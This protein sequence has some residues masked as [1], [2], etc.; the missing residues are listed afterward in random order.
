MPKTK[1]IWRKLFRNNIDL[2]HHFVYIYSAFWYYLILLLTVHIEFN[3]WDRNIMRNKWTILLVKL[4]VY[5][6]FLKC[7]IYLDVQERRY[8]EIKKLSKITTKGVHS[9]LTNAGKI[10]KKKYVHVTVYLRTNKKIKRLWS[11]F[12]LCRYLLFCT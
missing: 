11:S 10:R 8:G 3:D 6:P 1:I 9:K 12:F 7:M 5:R 2:G 4:R